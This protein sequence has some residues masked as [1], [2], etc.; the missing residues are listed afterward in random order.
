[1][2]RRFQVRVPIRLCD[3][4]GLQI[5]DVLLVLLVGHQEGVV[6]NCQARDEHPLNVFFEIRVNPDGVDYSIPEL[7][8]GF[9]AA[10]FD[11]A[12]ASVRVGGQIL[13]AIEDDRGHRLGA[14]PFCPCVADKHR[15]QQ[16][17]QQ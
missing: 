16:H 3:L 2:W 1:L 12:L 8:A 11:P 6:A 5:E 15:R 4:P 17:A 9:L 13:H 10:G 14:C 7:L